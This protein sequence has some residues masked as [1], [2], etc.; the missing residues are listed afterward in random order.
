[1][2]RVVVAQQGFDSVVVAVGVDE[3][4]VGRGADGILTL[5]GDLLEALAKCGRGELGAES[6]LTCAK[7]SPV[8][9]AT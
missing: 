4:Q 7:A 8:S 2:N 9:G 6:K 5:G 1:M 3:Q